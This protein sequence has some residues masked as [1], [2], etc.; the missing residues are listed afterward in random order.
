[1][2]EH[3]PDYRAAFLNNAVPMC[4]IDDDGRLCS[5]NRAATDYFRGA[6]PDPDEI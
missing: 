4:I 5:V 6:P 1:M 3:I 2:G